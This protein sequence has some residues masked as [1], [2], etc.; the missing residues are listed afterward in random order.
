VAGSVLKDDS[1]ALGDHWHAALG[2]DVCG[3]FAENP[4][5]FEQ[6]GGTDERAGV[7]SHGDGLIHIHPYADDET[8]DGATVGRFFEYGGW[9]L[10]SE[11]FAIWDGTQL[12]NGDAC[13]DGRT[14]RLRWVVNGEERNGNPADYE[15]E[16]G[17]VITIA[18]VPDGDQIPEPPSVASLPSPAK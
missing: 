15:P 16:D 11:G 3:S 1:P 2:I 10:G 6:R 14:G 13:P 4:P 5:S 17:D 12:A 8:G 7:H 9:G 18:F